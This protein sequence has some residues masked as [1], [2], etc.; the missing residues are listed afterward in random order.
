MSIDPT[1]IQG[2]VERR[3]AMDMSLKRGRP[4]T[5]V[6]GY[7]PERF[8]GLGAYGEVWVAIERE[9]GPKGGHQVLRPSR[10]TRLVALVPRGRETR[11]PV[12]RPLR[13]ATAGRRLGRRPAVLHHGV[14]GK[15]LAG[16]SDRGGS[17]AGR[18]GRIAVPRRGHGPGPRPRQGRVALRSET[19]QRAVGPG[20][21][22]AAGR[23]RSIAAVDRAGAGAGDDVLHGARAGRSGR[24]ARRPLGRLR[25]GGAVVLHVDGWPAA[26]HGQDGG[27]VRAD[28]RVGRSG[29]RTTGR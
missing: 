14:P 25:A 15:G 23:F 11:L 3:R 12:R 8:L 24:G 6:P 19:G 4:P 17:D 13:G 29:W 28:A 9:Y 5:Q 22:A 21:Q 7:E 1:E 20:R 26:P 2:G 16:R 10:R 18:R 27:R